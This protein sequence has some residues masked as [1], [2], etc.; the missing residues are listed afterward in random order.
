[1]RMK[2]IAGSSWRSGWRRARRGGWG[3]LWGGAAAG[4]VDAL[5][6]S[7]GG[8]EEMARE[9]LPEIARRVPARLAEVASRL[10]V[11]E[12]YY[13]SNV[14]DAFAILAEGGLGNGRSAAGSVTGPSRTQALGGVAQV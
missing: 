10:P 2:I 7:P 4:A 14:R 13:D 1:M 11:A 5:L 6:A 9:C 12:G 3:R 8:W